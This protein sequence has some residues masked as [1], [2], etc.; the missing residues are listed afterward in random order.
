MCFSPTYLELADSIFGQFNLP[1][2]GIIT[3]EILGIIA[4]KAQKELDDHLMEL[5][6]PEAYSKWGFSGLFDG[7]SCNPHGWPN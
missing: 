2:V 7:Q 5:G 3:P 1:T 4:Q 6:I